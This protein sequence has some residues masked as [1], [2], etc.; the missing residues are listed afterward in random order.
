MKF[1]LSKSAKFFFHF[2]EAQH[3]LREIAALIIKVYVLFSAVTLID[4]FPK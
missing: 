2:C 1:R 3:L 4:A